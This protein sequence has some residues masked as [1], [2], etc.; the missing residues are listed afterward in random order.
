MVEYYWDGK[1][2]LTVITD[3][4]SIRYYLNGELH[5]KNGPA[6]I[7]YN[8]YDY[9][10]AKFYYIK[11]SL[12]RENGPAE[13]DYYSNGNIE[14]KIYYK[15]GIIHREN[16]PANI[17]HNEYGFIEKKEYYFNGIKF[18][19]DNLPFKLPIDTEEKEF[20]L[21]LKYGE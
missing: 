13:I 9:I 2:W 6:L 15:N 18:N 10:R 7:L 8:N 14:T 17:Y 11:D 20:L 3:D 12:H 16:G 5:R 1:N 19:P 4:I 21:K